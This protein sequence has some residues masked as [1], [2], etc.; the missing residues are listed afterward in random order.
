MIQ[1]RVRAALVSEG[2]KNFYDVRYAGGTPYL[3][4]S[5]VVFD[6]QRITPYYVAIATPFTASQRALTVFTYLLIGALVFAVILGWA[7]NRTVGA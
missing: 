2:H 7:L 5:G 6:E 4:R 3:V 1:E